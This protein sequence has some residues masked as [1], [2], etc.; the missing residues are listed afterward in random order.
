MSKLL[1]A[2][3]SRQGCSAERTEPIKEEGRYTIIRCI[4][5]LPLRVCCSPFRSE[6]TLLCSAASL[7]GLPDDQYR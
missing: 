5:P 3:G 7:F 6:T 2:G 1:S 4:V